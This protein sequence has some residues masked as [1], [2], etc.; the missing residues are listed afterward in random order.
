MGMGRAEIERRSRAR[1]AGRH[2]AS[3]RS[4]LRM[5]GRLLVGEGMGTGCSEDVHWEP[6]S[7]KRGHCSQCAT[8]DPVRQVPSV[9]LRAR[10]ACRGRA[11]GSRRLSPPPP[12]R[13]R[14]V[15]WV[16]SP[17]R[18]RMAR[19]AA[20]RRSWREAVRPPALSAAEC[21][22]AAGR[23]GYGLKW[24]GTTTSGGL[25]ALGGARERRVRCQDGA[26]RVQR[27]RYVRGTCLCKGCKNEG[28]R[29][30]TREIL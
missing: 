26:D 28:A 18:L 8:P 14:A 3:R 5:P 17:R 1:W 27:A 24:L 15:S 7:V 10:P 16:V 2:R 25:R 29:G 11:N 12:R 21:Q 19:L 23:Q 6:E 30:G 9:G 13:V 22:Q 20:V 4:A